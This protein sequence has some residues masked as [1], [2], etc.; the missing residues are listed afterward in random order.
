MCE[1]SCSAKARESAP[2]NHPI[3]EPRKQ[4]AKSIYIYIVKVSGIKASMNLTR[5]HNLT[6]LHS[7]VATGVVQ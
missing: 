1:A 7:R 4:T 5:A 6:A 2:R 3:F